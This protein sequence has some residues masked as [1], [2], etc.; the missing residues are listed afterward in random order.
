MAQEASP[1]G[2][3][4]PVTGSETSERP[5]GRRARRGRRVPGVLVGSDAHG[6]VGPPMAS[7]SCS[8][9]W[10]R[11]V[12]SPRP[13]RRRSTRRPPNLVAQLRNLA[14]WFWEVSYDLLII[15]SL[16]LLAAGPV[17]ARA[18]TAVPVRAGRD[19]R[20]A[21]VRDPGRHART[22]PMPR[23]ASRGPDQLG[24]AR[25]LPGHAG[26]PGHRGDR[27]GVPGPGPPDASDGTMVD[28]DRG[29]LRGRARRRTADRDRRGVPGRVRNGRAG[30]PPLRLTRRA[31]HARSGDR[32]APRARRRRDRDPRRSAPDA[33]VALTLATTPEGRPLL[34]KMFG[35]MPRTANS[36]PPPGTR[37][38]TE[39]RSTSGRA[40]S[41]RSSTRRSS[42][43]PPSEPVFR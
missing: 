27:H 17:R 13:A 10:A 32:G 5:A 11:R 7:C 31:A 25:D 29:D 14:G 28:R 15:W 16:F 35:G 41:S 30:P 42:R 19:G 2:T 18:Q 21:R 4:E 6:R 33:G 23:R 36:S 22:A 9:C 1:A 24:V 37:S 12:S 3:V 26:R 40:G 39:A 38:G 20:R 34:V 43:W 8:R